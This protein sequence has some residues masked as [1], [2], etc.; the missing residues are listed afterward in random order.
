MLTNLV[1]VRIATFDDTELVITVDKKL[2]A[3]FLDCLILYQVRVEVEAQFVYCASFFS[4]TIGALLISNHKI[5]SS[6]WKI[7]SV[8]AAWE[9]FTRSE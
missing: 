5:P 8:L 2:L 1:V 3:D 4:P 7:D 6:P 9:S